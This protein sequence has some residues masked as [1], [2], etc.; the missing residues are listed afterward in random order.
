MHPRDDVLLPAIGGFDSRKAPGSVVS[1]SY[2]LRCE[3]LPPPAWPRL[4]CDR[5]VEGAANDFNYFGGEGDLARIARQR[6]DGGTRHYFLA[7]GTAHSRALVYGQY[8]SAAW[9]GSWYGYSGLR[10]MATLR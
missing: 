5:C 3:S 4:S 2:T 9:L 1:A 8:G 6:C 7:Q 10:V